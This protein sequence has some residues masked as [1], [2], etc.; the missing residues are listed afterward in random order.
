MI[1]KYTTGG[2]IDERQIM[3]YIRADMLERNKTLSLTKSAAIQ[4]RSELF[5]WCQS[6][7]FMSDSIQ[8]AL[9]HCEGVPLPHA[10][11][12]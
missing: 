4:V 10:F 3:K 12:Y 6:V 11:E 7:S 1:I 8:A 2:I 5:V 9:I